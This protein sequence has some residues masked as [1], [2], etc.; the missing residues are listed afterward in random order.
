MSLGEPFTRM[1]EPQPEDLVE[2]LTVTRMGEH[3]I[4]VRLGERYLQMSEYSAAQIVGILSLF[5][6][7]RFTKACGKAIKLGR[8]TPGY[9]AAAGPFVSLRPITIDI[10][11]VLKPTPQLPGGDDDAVPTDHE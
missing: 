11:T 10:P 1:P 2:E 6:G 8:K 4:I 9:Q 5:L 3:H 7:I